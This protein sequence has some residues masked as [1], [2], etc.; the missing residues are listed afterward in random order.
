MEDIGRF[1]GGNGSAL[2][3]PKTLLLL[4]LVGWVFLILVHPAVDL[5]DGT[6]PTKHVLQAAIVLFASGSLLALLRLSRFPSLLQPLFTR[7]C[8]LVF[9]VPIRC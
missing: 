4:M 7:D 8:L 1:V 2:P 6:I 9:T 3:R 5:P